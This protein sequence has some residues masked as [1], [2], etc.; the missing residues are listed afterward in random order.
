MTLDGLVVQ[1]KDCRRPEAEAEAEAPNRIMNLKCWVRN[2]EMS[3]GQ[4]SGR[5]IAIV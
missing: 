1:G 2:D 4:W 5:V 3:G